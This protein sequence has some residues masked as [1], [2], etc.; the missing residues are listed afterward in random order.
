MAMSGFTILSP[1]IAKVR[2]S[3]S[4][5]RS[6]VTKSRR[7]YVLGG[8][9]TLNKLPLILIWPTLRFDQKRNGRRIH[10]QV[11]TVIRYT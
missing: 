5:A 7:N 10:R 4:A 11:L 1:T 3:C 8:R 2:P 9:S 6:T